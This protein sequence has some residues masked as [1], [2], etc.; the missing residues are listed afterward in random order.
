MSSPDPV[1]PVSSLSSAHPDHLPKG[2]RWKKVRQPCGPDTQCRLQASLESPPESVRI[3]N[4]SG[5]GISLILGR[6][7]E[8]GTVLTLDLFNRPHRFD[9][10]VTMRVV[11]VGGLGA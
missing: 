11:S 2:R 8:P 4:L 6:R 9:C 10:Q 5:F 3:R 7:L 1:S